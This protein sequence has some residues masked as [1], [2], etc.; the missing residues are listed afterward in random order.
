MNIPNNSV[1][2]KSLN[3]VKIHTALSQKYPEPVALVT[4]SD[5]I[6]KDN[7]MTVAW[8]M[9]TSLKPELLA[10]SI[11]KTRFS[12]NLIYDTNEFV[13][14]FPSS[15]QVKA[16]LYC[17]THSGRNVDKFAETGLK[18]LKAK[19]VKP[20]LIDG[21]IACFECKV[22]KRVETGDH[23]IFIGKILTAHMFHKEN[24]MKLF[25]F[26]KGI[27]RCLKY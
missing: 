7:V 16:V 9:Q 22:V 12:H 27:L 17:G 24:K 3:G 13:L 5:K 23:T 6:G 14:C 2:D 18:K 19:Y 15:K 8:F 26:G 1:R 21:S 10:I 20:S 4:S 25:N 11:G